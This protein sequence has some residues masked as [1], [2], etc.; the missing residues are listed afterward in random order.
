[1]PK[2]K[3]LRSVSFWVQLIMLVSIVCILYLPT[4]HFSFI[5]DDHAGIQQN[6][7]IQSL[8]G[9]LVNPISIFRSFLLYTSYSLGQLDPAY[10]RVMNIFFHL[11]TVVGIYALVLLVIE[12]SIIAFCSALLF[13]V[14][15]ILVESVVWI[16][17]LTYPQY[18]FFVLCS[19]I[20]YIVGKKNHRPVYSIL[21]FISFILSVLSSEK[22]LV[23]P[24][25]LCMYEWLFG[26]LKKN[27]KPIA[28]TFGVILI[29]GLMLF[30]F[31]QERITTFSASATTG[32]TELLN[33]FIQVPTVLG[34]YIGLTYWPAR[35][36]IYHLDELRVQTI[37]L[38]LNS[39]LLVGYVAALIFSIL[40]NK[41]IFFFLSI[42]LIASLPALI[43]IHIIQ[44]AAERYAYLGT[45]GLIIGTVA[46]LYEIL[47]KYSLSKK[48]LTVLLLCC[49]VALGWRTYLRSQDWKSEMSLRLATLRTAPYSAR[50]H[51]NVGIELMNQNKDR[52][53][54][55]EFKK[56]ISLKSDYSHPYH[57]IG[58]L[59][60]VRGRYEEAVPYYL[61][62]MHLNSF[63]WKTHQDLGQVYFMLKKYPEAREQLN[64]AI[65]Q[66]SPEVE[67][68][69]AILKRI[70][71]LGY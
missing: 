60:A 45:A 3:N 14:H 63:E 1:M 43:P 17:S 21:F 35:F 4:L 22:A 16:S 31:V 46:G 19:I 62:A 53:A 11:A 32:T 18:S 51:N 71:E 52:E 66:G 36:T 47:E 12:S 58:H 38:M 50:A 6:T 49:V 7:N 25:I 13:A 27:W 34:T 20:F 29:F 54:L 55:V 68:L 40:K 2:V 24:I 30:P 64:R 39:V 5:L 37:P 28:T 26:S 56:S 8:E 59:L 41:K 48:V 44:I 15:P 23:L 10:Y 42:F 67:R 70:E 57:N 69:G 65:E 33:P 61:K 9:V